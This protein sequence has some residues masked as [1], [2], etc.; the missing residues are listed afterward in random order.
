MKVF[1]SVNIDAEIHGDVKLLSQL[2]GIP[3]TTIIET[4]LRELLRARAD[5]LKRFKSTV[6]RLRNG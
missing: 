2:D 3:M 4:Q 1:K 6:Q 5:E